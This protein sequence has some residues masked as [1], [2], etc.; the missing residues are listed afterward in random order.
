MASFFAHKESALDNKSP[1]IAIACAIDFPLEET[2]AVPSMLR[3]RVQEMQIPRF[4]RDD[5]FST[6][7]PQKTLR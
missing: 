4:V 1:P 7:D 3:E 2:I 5:R 6:A